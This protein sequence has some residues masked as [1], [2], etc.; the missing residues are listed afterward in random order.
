MLTTAQLKFIDKH[1]RSDN[2]LI[3]NDL[4]AELT[5]HYVDAVT[6]KVA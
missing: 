5:D 3:N 1:L 4:I 6:D 2:W